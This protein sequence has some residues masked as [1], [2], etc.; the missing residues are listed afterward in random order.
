M[1][2]IFNQTA[3]NIYNL[4]DIDT[5]CVDD[6]V[7]VNGLPIETYV[8]QRTRASKAQTRKALLRALRDLDEK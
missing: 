1:T 5:L 3:K 8:E 7:C 6:D 2:R 4:G